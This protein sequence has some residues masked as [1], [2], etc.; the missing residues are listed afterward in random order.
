MQRRMDLFAAACD[1]F[2]LVINTEKTVFMHEPPSDAAYVAPQINVSGAPTP[3]R[4]QNSPTLA[5][6]FPVDDEVARRTSNASQAFGLLQNTFWNRYSLHLNTK[7]KV[8]KAVILPMLLF[9]AETWTAYM[10]QARRLNHFHFRC[11][12]RLLNL[13]WQD[14]ITDTDVPE[15]TGILSICALLRQLQL[16][17]NGHLVRMDDKRPPKLLFYGDLSRGS[18]RKGGEIRRYK[19]TLKTSLRSLQINLANWVDLGRGTDLRGGEQ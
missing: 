13:R 16:C 11:L 14:R 8:Y 17:W 9:G 10:K 3:S 4:G 2:D 12:R 1:N 19:D 6:R 15:P 7:L 18:R 5:A